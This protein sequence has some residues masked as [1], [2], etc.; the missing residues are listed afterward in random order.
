MDEV[1]P[2][3]G[4]RGRALLSQPHLLSPS[5]LG[6]HLLRGD[7]NKDPPSHVHGEPRVRELSGPAHVI[8]KVLAAMLRVAYLPAVRQGTQLL[9]VDLN[10]SES[11]VV[12]GADSCAA[13]IEV[14]LALYCRPL[15][16]R[17]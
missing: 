14:D 12:P 8:H 16:C 6:L 3:H 17:G 2:R 13:M 1:P 9:R 11:G 7:V 10:L 5:S 15:L 4:G